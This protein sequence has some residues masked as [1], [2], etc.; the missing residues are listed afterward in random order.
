MSKKFLLENDD[1]PMP[2]QSSGKEGIKKRVA[3]DKN[4]GSPPTHNYYHGTLGRRWAGNG[5]KADARNWKRK[6]KTQFL[7]D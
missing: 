4:P 1:L 6:R 7:T 2:S 5:K 3:T